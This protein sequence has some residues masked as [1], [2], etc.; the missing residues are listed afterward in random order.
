MVVNLHSI[1]CGRHFSSSF[2]HGVVHQTR[3]R[4]DGLLVTI[5]EIGNEVF[6]IFHDTFSDVGS[7][8]P[9]DPVEGWPVRSQ[10]FT[11]IL[12][13]APPESITKGLQDNFQLVVVQKSLETALPTDL[14]GQIGPEC[15]EWHLFVIVWHATHVTSRL[16]GT[17]QII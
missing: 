17:A 3:V 2:L 1:R 15:I 13:L 12:Q 6:S 11:R 16:Q 8:I 4:L 7:S 9:K 14:N 5:Q 10:D